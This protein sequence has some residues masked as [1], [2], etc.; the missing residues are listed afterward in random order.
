MNAITDAF[1]RFL[2]AGSITRTSKTPESNSIDI[3]NFPIN[4]QLWLANSSPADRRTALHLAARGNHSTVLQLLLSSPGYDID[5]RDGNGW[6]PLHY[7]SRFGHLT[8]VSVLLDSYFAAKG[9]RDHTWCTPLH[10]AAVSGY[11]GVVETLLR[12]G[13]D[14]DSQDDDGWA[15]LHYA[16]NNGYAGVVRLL[17]L[18]GADGD[19]RDN[20]GWTGLHCAAMD[21][22]MEVGSCWRRRWKRERMMGVRRCI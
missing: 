10:H 1:A 7:A 2:G 22:H 21:D 8:I 5:P 3:T 13:V 16:A 14:I 6:T 19:A 18:F 11:K 12:H 4:D 15:A 20:D 17:L 9:A